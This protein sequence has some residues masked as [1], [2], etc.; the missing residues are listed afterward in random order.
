MYR[1]CPS[2]TVSVWGGAQRRAKTVPKLSIAASKSGTTSPT[3]LT[4]LVTEVHDASRQTYGSIRVHAELTLGRGMNVGLHQVALGMRRAGLRG[5]V[6][7]RKR[8]RIEQPDAWISVDR[9]FARSQRDR[10]WVT[11]IT[12]RPTREGRLYCCVVLD[13]FS[14]PR[15]RLVD[16]RI[17]D[18][19][20]RDQR[21]G[22][23][24]QLT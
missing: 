13:V 7:R 9:S 2:G 18:G 21:V 1:S 22:D 4:D 5:L 12:E 16:R 11:D 23:G 8:P 19:G 14:R 3:W 6:G 10:L 24:H 15:R 17:A 20:A